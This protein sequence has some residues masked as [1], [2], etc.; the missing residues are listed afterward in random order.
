MKYLL[1]LSA[2]LVITGVRGQ[3]DIHGAFDILTKFVRQILKSQPDDYKI[4][5]GVHL[6]SK[7]SE[8]NARANTDD[9]T[10]IGVLENYLETHEL[11]IKLA[12]LMP[13]EGFGRSFKSA[14]GE[15]YGV[16]NESELIGM[17]I[18]AKSVKPTF[19]CD[20]TK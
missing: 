1:L 5:D 15:I 14:V 12:D 4:G 11:R 6:L 13:G 9:G 20:S 17:S 7:R 8:N 10:V 19:I 3:S 18:T 2:F 16:G